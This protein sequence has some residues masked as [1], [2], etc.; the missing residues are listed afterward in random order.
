MSALGLCCYMGFFCSCSR[1]RL[2]S[3]CGARVSRCGASL[4]EER[5]LRARRLQQLQLQA[6][7][8]RLN[9]CGYVVLC[10]VTQAC[11]T[12]CNPM[13]PLSM[14]DSPA[15]ILQWVVMP[16]SRGSSR[17]RD[18]TQVSPLQE[19]SLPPEPP[20]GFIALPVCIRSAGMLPALGCFPDQGS[21]LYLLHWQLDS[22]P[23]SR[24]GSP[25]FWF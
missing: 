6:L 4:V 1:W 15:R 7:E 16:S 25:W 3:S 21:N 22:S 23:L 10:L 19:D 13:A 24:Q 18:R 2:L 17:P 20:R 9:S 12:L 14:G 8:H 5:G 11:L